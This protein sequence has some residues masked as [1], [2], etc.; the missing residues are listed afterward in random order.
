MLAKPGAVIFDLDGTLLDT[1]PL[2][3]Q[4]TQQIVTPYGKHF[5]L[6][7]KQQIMGGD[8]RVGAATVISAL[9]LPLDVDDYLTRREVL[10]T[11]LFANAPEIPG[12]GEFI[13]LLRDK[14]LSIGL[15]TS[16]NKHLCDL[17]LSGHSWKT[18]FN[19]IVCGDDP[20]LC[21]PKPAPDIFLMCA[22]SM[23]VEP[24]DCIVFEDSRHGIASALAAGMQVVAVESPYVNPGDLNQAS[25]SVKDYLE[26]KTHIA[27]W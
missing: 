4:A 22:E 1:E 9:E 24:T 3:T 17:K 27:H 20:N 16:S 25:C 13:R 6:A 8:A 21:A 12:A 5:D 15:A 10:L 18:Q 7:L 23:A 19:S 2:Y 26:A 14:G 11:E